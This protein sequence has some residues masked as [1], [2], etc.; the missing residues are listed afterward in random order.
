MKKHWYFVYVHE[1]PICGMFDEH[2]ERRYTP[3]PKDW[4]ER[5]LF[6]WTSCSW[7]WL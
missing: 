3:K 7:H 4:R 2:R 1:C 5:F 6:R